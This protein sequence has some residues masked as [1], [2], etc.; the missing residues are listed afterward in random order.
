MYIQLSYSV[1]T[2]D[3]KGGTNTTNIPRE[4]F[5]INITDKSFDAQF[6][7]VAIH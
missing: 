1:C 6:I 4:T 2:N 7:N 3:V 5:I